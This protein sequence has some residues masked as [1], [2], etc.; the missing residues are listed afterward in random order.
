MTLPSIEDQIE[1]LRSEGELFASAVAQVSPDDRVPSCP[2]WCVRDLV[3]HTGGVHRWATRHV[4]EARTE[5]IDEDLDTLVGA[6]PD[7]GSLATWLRAG[8]EGLADALAAAPADLQ[9]FAFLPAPSPREF[10][11][12]RQLHET[13][14]HR[15]DAE[16]A[17]STR[18]E[19]FPDLAADGIEEVLFGFAARPGKLH[20]EVRSQLVLRTTD[21]GDVWT[22]EVG[23]DGGGASR[24]GID[25]PDGDIFSRA[26]DL[27]LLLWNRCTVRDM[28]TVEG[29]VRVAEDW[30][31]RMRV[32]WS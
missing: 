24:G 9:A 30:P 7:D 29:D 32:R 2:D 5:P 22:I 8:V 13:T 25:A 28:L 6:W 14:I 16:Q 27:Y 17:G 11:A 1:D 12:R 19:V 3:R 15:V 20:D 21:T 23:P 18:P 31:Q 26:S 10:W 4:A